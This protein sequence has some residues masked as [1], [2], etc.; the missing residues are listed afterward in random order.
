MKKA[1]R[2]KYGIKGVFPLTEKT[3]AR[4]EIAVMLLNM[5]GPEKLFVLINKLFPSIIDK[6]LR[7][8]VLIMSEYV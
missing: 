6:A 7:K 8:N 3:A 4:Q 2:I 5:G 1:V